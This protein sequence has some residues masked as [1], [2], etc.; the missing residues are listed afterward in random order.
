MLSLEI[1]S[2]CRVVTPWA[3]VAGWDVTNKVSGVLTNT[4]FRRE[5]RMA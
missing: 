2:V 4:K 1:V 3:G 5:R